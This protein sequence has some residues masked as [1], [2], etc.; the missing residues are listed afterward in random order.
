MFETCPLPEHF[1]HPSR[2]HGQRHVARVMVH[3]TRLIDATGLHTHANALWAAVFLH[4]LARTH[5]GVCHRHG[6]DA[7]TRYEQEPWLQEAI[8]PARLSA[9]DIDG[10]RTAVVAHCQWQEVPAEDP[11]ITLVKLLK[12]ADGLDR[13]RIHDLD[14]SYLRFPESREMEA[15]AWDLHAYSLTVDEG[16]E[17][18]ARLQDWATRQGRAPR[19]SWHRPR[20]TSGTSPTYPAR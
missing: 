10:V 13:V 16:P 9:N 19:A 4:D 7:W 14:V 18:F 17:L 3:A 6:A 1:R 2:V 15:F 11:H 12:D 20:G 8:E 5:D